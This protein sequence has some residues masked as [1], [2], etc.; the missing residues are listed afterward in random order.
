M[1]QAGHICQ[2]PP[3]KG[4]L[5]YREPILTCILNCLAYFDLTGL[6][7]YYRAGSHLAS[8]HFLTAGRRIRTIPMV[9]PGGR[10]LPAGR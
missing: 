3:P 5:S 10:W 2:L 6:L 4:S 7:K 8:I 1:D 9:A